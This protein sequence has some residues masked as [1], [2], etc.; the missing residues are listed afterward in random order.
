MHAALGFLGCGRGTDSAQRGRPGLGLRSRAAPLLG[1]AC[2]GH[3]APAFLGM[4]SKQGLPEVVGLVLQ[5]CP[6]HPSL[7]KK[8]IKMSKNG[9]FGGAAACAL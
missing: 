4:K 5:S 1:P 2:C 9:F 7:K 6:A 8:P 3:V